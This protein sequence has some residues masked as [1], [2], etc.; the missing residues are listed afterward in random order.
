MGAPPG[1]DEAALTFDWQTRRLVLVGGRTP[2]GEFALDVWE[3]DNVTWRK[4]APNGATP[5]PRASFG[6]SSSPFARD[7]ILIGGTATGGQPSSEV[8]RLGYRAEG[9]PDETCDNGTDDDGDR[10]VDGSDPDCCGRTGPE[11]E[12]IARCLGP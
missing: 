6:M 12:R 3:L 9:T 8:W 1:R 10:H 2:T 11:A 4:L 7:T 5:L